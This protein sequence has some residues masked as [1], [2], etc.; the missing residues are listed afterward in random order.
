MKR[1]D[2]KNRVFVDPDN[3]GI[4]KNMVGLTQGKTA[5]R[6]DGVEVEIKAGD[7]AV[8]EGIVIENPLRNRL[9]EFFCVLDD[10]TPHWS[11]CL[12]RHE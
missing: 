2:L 9:H 10:D 3:E 11:E 6:L 7:Y 12:K 5:G 8:C 1:V 4:M